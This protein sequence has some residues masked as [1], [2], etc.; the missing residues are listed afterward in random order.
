MNMDRRNRIFILVKLFVSHLIVFTSMNIIIILLKRFFQMDLFKEYEVYSFT[1]LVFVSFLL[2]LITL[3]DYIYI[4]KAIRIDDRFGDVQKVKDAM[5]RLKWKIESEYDD[6]IV[7]K[8]KFL[9]GI[10]IDRIRVTFTDTEIHI[11]G[12]KEYVKKL[13]SIANFTYKAYDLYNLN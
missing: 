6:T 2:S 1:A 7:F 9:F 13:I 5:Q 12:S 4:K 3:S 11:L 8:S 10:W